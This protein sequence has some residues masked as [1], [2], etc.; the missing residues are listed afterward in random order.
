[1]EKQQIFEIVVGH[2]R[3]ILP[4]LAAHEFR[5]D[6][7]LKDLGANSLDRSEISVMTLDT[8]GL[9]IPLVELARVT[10]I[11]ELVDVLHA[12]LHAT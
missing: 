12:R 6:D 4:S 5:R 3:D 10:N 2:A 9:R 11:G 8:L 7:A 1:M